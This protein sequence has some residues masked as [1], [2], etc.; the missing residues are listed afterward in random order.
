MLVAL[1][2]AAYWGGSLLPPVPGQQVG[3]NVFPMVIGAALVA[4]GVLIMV[5]VGRSFEEDEK[6]VTSASGAVADEEAVEAAQGRMA[7]FLRGGWKIL[8]PPAALFFYYFAS[9]R[10]GFW[11]TASLMVFALAWS[12]GAKVKWALGLAVVAPALVHL[13]F[14]KLLRVPLP[15][16]LLAFPWA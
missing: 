14:Y 16:G 7:T 5:G 9:E 12:Q 4:C 10:L 3:P 13:T 1:G 15:P 2:G 6:I 11:I 8:L